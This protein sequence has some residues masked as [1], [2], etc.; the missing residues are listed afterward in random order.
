MKEEVFDRN[1]GSESAADES[2]TKKK[3]DRA[4]KERCALYHLCFS[5]RGLFASSCRTRNTDENHQYGMQP[6]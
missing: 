4:K 2:G 5:R 6:P 3:S 1:D